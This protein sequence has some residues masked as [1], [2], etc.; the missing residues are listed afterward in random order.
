MIRLT[1]PFRRAA[2][3]EPTRSPASVARGQ[4]R[5]CR[6][7]TE[8]RAVGD[9]E[10]AEAEVY[11]ARIRADHQHALE[12]LTTATNARITALEE[13]RDALRV[14][15][16]RAESDLDPARAENQRLAEQLTQTNDAGHLRHL[17]A[18][19]FYLLSTV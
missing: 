17:A 4:R 12:Q 6:A 19:V 14:R 18:Q 2:L 10:S 1:S 13:T 16:E 15:A 7:I 11:A 9:I 5:C 3:P 8:L